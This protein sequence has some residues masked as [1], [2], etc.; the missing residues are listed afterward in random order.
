MKSINETDQIIAKYI[1]D[2]VYYQ[3]ARTWYNQKYL[4]MI[5]QRARIRVIIFIIAAAF[6]GMLYTYS[7]N[8]V[9][10]KYPFPIYAYD[11]TEYFPHIKPLSYDKEPI[12]N[13]VS[14][15]LLKKYVEFR[16]NYN[17]S[18]YTGEG[19]DI[20]IKRIQSLSSRKVLK[21]YLDYI[22]PEANPQSPL[23]LYKLHSTRQVTVTDVKF[24]NHDEAEVYYNVDLKNNGDFTLTTENSTTQWKALISF[25]LSDIAKVVNKKQKLAFVVINYQTI[26]L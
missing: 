12:T 10:K 11:E 23:V 1:E 18:D 21:Q 6:L 19:R 17:Y 5:S 8:V 22:D 26:K 7:L 25:K 15:Y 13:S 3:D 16:E 24:I 4:S 14:R 20:Q 2:G 9:S